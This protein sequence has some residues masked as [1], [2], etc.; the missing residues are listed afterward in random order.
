[1]SISKYLN[2]YTVINKSRP[3]MSTTRRFLF[4]T[5]VL[6]YLLLSPYISNPGWN[7]WRKFEVK[8]IMEV[9]NMILEGEEWGERKYSLNT[10]TQHGTINSVGIR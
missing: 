2:I 9:L 4:Y 10:H 1:M 8:E 6:F 5:E 7:S 3:R